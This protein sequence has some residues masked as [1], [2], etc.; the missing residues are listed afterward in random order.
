M[1]TKRPTLSSQLVTLTELVQQNQSELKRIA[2]VQERI[3]AAISPQSPP[4]KFVVLTPP[5]SYE[6]PDIELKIDAREWE[7]ITAGR[8]LCIIGQGYSFEGELEA[9]DYWFFEGGIKRGRLE[10]LMR[11]FFNKDEPDYMDPKSWEHAFE[12]PI[13]EVTIEEYDENEALGF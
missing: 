6:Y 1:N 5:M 12:G 11:E 8:S 10:V 2:T 3:L 9:Q 7:A 4:I 13:S